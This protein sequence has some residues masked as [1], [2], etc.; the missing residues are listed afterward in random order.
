MKKDTKQNIIQA[1]TK[2]FNQEGFGKVS[3]NEVAKSLGL[4]RGN[5]AYHFKDKDALLVAI[6][7]QMWTDLEAK[8]DKK[9]SLPSFK[10]LTEDFQNLYEV[11]RTYS[12]IFLDTHV[13]RHRQIKTQFREMMAKYI[14]DNKTIIAYAVQIGNMKPESVPGMYHQLAHNAWMISFFWLGQQSVRGDFTEQRA[15]K[16][17]WSLLLPHFTEQGKDAFC[18]FL[19][20]DYME[21][22]GEAFEQS[23]NDLIKI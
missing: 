23:M 1:A 3:M 11:Q 4:S 21:S 5:L 14:E 20:K 7:Q 8:R 19:G 22:M 9:L 15:D 13:L 2:L 16:A 10:N 18:K 12:F 17:I 6:V